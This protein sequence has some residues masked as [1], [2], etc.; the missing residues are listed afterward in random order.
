MSP[1]AGADLHL[2]DALGGAGRYRANRREVVRDVT[3]TPVAELTLAPALYI[4]RTMDKLRSAPATAAAWP[5]ELRA[6]RLRSAARHFADGV[7]AGI[8][9]DEHHRLVAGTTGV[10]VAV[11]RAAAATIADVAAHAQDCVEL[12]RP[13]GALPSGA[14]AGETGPAGPVVVWRRRGRVFSVQ[15]SGNHPAVHSLWLESLALGYRVA[16]RPSRR[17]PF[18][19]YRLVLALRAAGFPDDDVLLLPCDHAT[20]GELV[21]GGDLAMVFGGD[22][23]LARYG[24]SG[25]RTPILPQGPGRVK[26]LITGD[27]EPHLEVVAESVAGLGGVSCLNTTAVLVEHD[28]PGFARAL[29]ERLAQAKPLPPEDE[30]A[31]LPCTSLAEARAL[32]AFLRAS[33]TGATPVLGGD[34]IAHDLGDG[35]AA[36]RPAVHLLADPGSGHLDIELPFPCAWVAPWSASLGVA[37]LRHSLVVG[38]AAKSDAMVDDLVAEPSVRNIY[39]LDRPTWWLPPGVPHDGFLAEFLMRSTAVARSR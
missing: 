10:P 15:A 37:P 13:A 14:R 23:V 20:A 30:A 39:G 5:P 2:I 16:V 27:W 36:L 7:L 22:E 21:H 25:N 31:E 33:A 8:A 38:L 12:A 1:A 28:A 4:A 6:E 29:A 35:S 3:G 17:D 18:T 26:V 34:G 11:A 19:A 32:D 9:P 24:A